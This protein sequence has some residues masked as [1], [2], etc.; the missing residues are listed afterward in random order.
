[1]MERLNAIPT[2][3][4][5]FPC[6]EEEIAYTGV[7]TTALHNILRGHKRRDD[8]EVVPVRLPQ[9]ELRLFDVVNAIK[10]QIAA[11]LSLGEGWCLCGVMLILSPQSCQKSTSAIHAGIPSRLA[12]R[13]RTM[14]CCFECQ[15]PAMQQGMFSR[16]FMRAISQS[17]HA[18]KVMFQISHL[19]SIN[20]STERASCTIQHTELQSQKRQFVASTREIDS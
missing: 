14:C 15:S 8:D 4:A 12:R 3:T 9:G 2:V 7:M 16:N 19:T 18:R 13:D 11:G 1:M 5:I 6:G 17:N 10:R 20:R